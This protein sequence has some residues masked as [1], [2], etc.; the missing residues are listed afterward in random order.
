MIAEVRLNENTEFG[1]EFS[2]VAR[3]FGS[4]ALFGTNFAGLAPQAPSNNAE[5]GFKYL[6]SSGEDKYAYIRGLA[7]TGNFKILA[8]PQLAAVSGTEATLDVGQEVPIITRT[9]SDTNSA[10]TLSTSNEVEYKKTGIMLKVTPQ[11]TKGGLITLE[12]DQVVSVRG[13]DV[14]AGGQ[15]Y[16]SFINREVVTSLSMR[17]GATL[18][19]GGII[20]ET[21]RSQNDSLP[22]IAKVPLLA[23]ALGYTTKQ[24]ERTE[25]LIMITASVIDEDSKLQKMIKRYKQSIKT[26]RDFNKSLQTNK[27]KQSDDE[28]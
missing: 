23:T 17:D 15:F 20:Q 12:L 7:G 10:S 1:V 6:I 14:Q 3:N 25:L 4:S 22:L 18:L 26:I 5:R 9:L 24:I 27:K 21:D 13:E 28:T 2:G 11:V 16:P 8:S 19:V